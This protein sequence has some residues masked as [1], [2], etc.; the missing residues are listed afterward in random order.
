MHEAFRPPP[1]VSLKQLSSLLNGAIDLEA[2]FQLCSLVLIEAKRVM[3][4][5]IL[6]DESKVKRILQTYLLSVAN[7]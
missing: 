1:H 5:N 6:N 7:N 2:M 3:G 4:Q